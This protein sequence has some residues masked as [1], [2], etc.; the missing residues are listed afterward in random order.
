MTLTPENS[1][2]PVWADDLASYGIVITDAT[3]TIRGW[4]R[5]MEI[6]SGRAASAVLGCNLLAIYPQ[7]TERQL[8][9]YYQQALAGQIAMLAQRLHGY[10]LP[11]PAP[12]DLTEFA[13]M[14]QSARIGPLV[15]NA[16]VVGTV[17]LIDDVTE[18]VATEAE[19]SRLLSQE[20][21]ARAQ[22][23]ATAARIARLQRVTAALSQ[24]LTPAQVA[25][26]IVL[27]STAAMETSAAVVQL[28]SEDGASLETVRALGYPE[29]LV[30]TVQRIPLS[31]PLPGTEAARLGQPIWL[32]SRQMLAARY[33]HLATPALAS[34]YEASAI[35][36]LVVEK[37][38][39]GVMALGFGEPRA[40]GLEDREFLLTL[41]H[42]CAQALERARLYEA[43]QEAIRIRDQFLSIA[44]HELKTPLT[45]LLGNSQLLQRRMMREGGMQERDQRT[46][47][48]IAE[49]ATRLNGM[50]TM[51]L[52]ISRIETGRL[53]IAHEPINLGT[54][55][56]R[57]T[58]EIEPLLTRHQI[59]CQTPDT[60][61]IIEGDE[62][63]LEQVLQ[64]L[65][66]NAVKYS[67]TGGKIL[68][69]AACQADQAHIV[70]S[71]EGIGIP[72]DALPHLF[73]RFYRAANANPQHISG[74]GIGLFVVKEIITLHGGTVDVE[75][76]EGQGSTFTVR[77]PLARTAS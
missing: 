68:I 77:L 70:V 67:P 21:A 55:V 49:Q 42:Q 51:L 76:I 54:L 40:F 26:V 37:R 58:M 48:L 61:P 34:G 5:W 25:D 57:V 47:R 71:D 1:A 14:Q 44:S 28:L 24:A 11:M 38:V 18:R 9:R 16:Q 63:R 64:N 41:A 72:A 13:Y 50:I 43:A 56:R 27:E 30:A 17:T 12:E 20:Q 66:Q 59:V 31:I 35:I 75:S 74:M 73:Q 33:P 39:L 45:S 6:H 8:E 69:Q 2:L 32:E 65:I 23:E 19:L 46:L 29:H 4:N 15:E 62:L 53:S 60:G 52:D 22:A 7:L 36:P 10:L 3:L